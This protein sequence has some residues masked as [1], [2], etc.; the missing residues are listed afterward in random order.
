VE[1][2]R[3]VAAYAVA[4]G[5]ANVPLSGFG[6]A[7]PAAQVS[8]VSLETE[9]PVDDVR[10]EFSSGA[11]SYVQAKRTLRKGRPL[12]SAVEQWVR[13]AR[14]GLQPGRDHLVIVTGELSGP[15]KVLQGVLRRL[16]T[17]RP[18]AL[19]GKEE[20]ELQHLRTLLEPLGE[21]DQA[22]VLK[23]AS[24]H[25][26]EVEEPED[27]GA[28]EAT[29]LL[30]RFVDA[31][32]LARAWRALVRVAGV[33]ARLR[34]GFDMRGWLAQLRD[35]GLAIS[36]SGGTVAA[37]LEAERRAVERYVADAERKAA[38]I[39][40]RPL[41]A[42]VAPIPIVDIDAD[43]E[44]HEEDRRGTTSL[45]WSFL[46][47][48]RVILTGLPGAGKST[49]L[50]HFAALIP[51]IDE[52][53][54]IRA[55]LRDIDAQDH[56]RPF[57]DR[58]L[59]VALRDVPPADRPLLVAN[60]S[61]RLDGGDAVLLLDGLDETYQRRAAVVAEVEAF[62]AS[63]SEHVAVL[64]S[65]R[66]VA[67]GHAATIGWPDLRLAPPKSIDRLVSAVL[68]ACQAAAARRGEKVDG[69]DWVA[70]RETWVT[71]ALGA[72][73][74][75]RETPLVPILLALLAGERDIK[76]LPT[77]RANVMRAVVES[78]L[79]RRDSDSARLVVGDLVG[80]AAVAAAAYVFAVEARALVDSGGQQAHATLQ[81]SVAAA[82]AEHWGLAPGPARVAADAAIRFWD[83]HGI[84]VVSGAQEVVTPR[85]PLFSEIGDAMAIVGSTPTGLA[86]WV[87]ERAA[88][89]AVESL[90][91]AAGLL[92]EAAEELAAAAVRTGDKA[93]LHGAV[94]A[95]LDGAVLGPETVRR[96][97][98]AHLADIAE[99]GREGWS[100]LGMLLRLPADATTPEA[101]EAVLD[102]YPDEHQVIARASIALHFRMPDELRSDPEVL[103]EALATS[104]IKRL[105]SRF[106]DEAPGWRALAVDELY[107]R[108]IERAAELLVG[109]VEGAAELVVARLQTVSMATSRRLCEVLEA[110]GMGDRVATAASES[111]RNTARLLANL[112]Y[113]PDDYVRFLEAVASMSP[114]ANLEFPVGIKLD[115]LADFVETM[116]LN[117]AG[118]W[119]SSFRSHQA[120]VIELVATLGSFDRSVLAAEAAIVLDRIAT[121]GGHEP[122]FSLFDG[123]SSR[124]LDDWSSVSSPEDA[125]R[126]LTRM[127]TWGLGSARLAASAL[128][129]A[130]VR[131]LAVPKLRE[132][133]P[134]LVSSAEHERV[135][136]LTLCSMV[137]GPEPESWLH[138]DD[139]ILRAV[140][141][142][143]LEPVGPEGR[144]TPQL[145]ELLL[146]ADRNVRAEAVRRLA[147]AAAVDRDQLLKQVAEAAEPGW[148]CLSCRTVNLPVATSCDE[149]DC[150]RV[151]S[152]PAADARRI[153]DG[154]FTPDD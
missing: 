52:W 131:E 13:A 24:M 121:F 129:A 123:A 134:K 119:G 96:V 137:D 124:P 48:G 78:L 116:L 127:L 66:D 51:R 84:F 104:R 46:R 38:S 71:S 58:L 6:V 55:S 89:G 146:D 27:T 103:L 82:L 39:D 154:T 83:E 117:D 54:P 44:V 57:R 67:Y 76:R 21:R 147:S 142:A 98:H 68:A 17:D 33:T 135:A 81:P 31:S 138:D 91:L 97:A 144:V 73:A 64:L 92:P 143:W 62:L 150:H 56:A 18:A 11:I 3:A 90:V 145:R 59:E 63:C 45:L 128:W 70:A 112:D 12:N 148:M 20:A 85:L 122:F 43:V 8:T 87:A 36:A 69:A 125:V 132:L 53:L 80:D 9:D 106:H 86:S 60:L 141:A 88:Q 133:L 40:L 35:E 2:R 34:G 61:R 115:H 107:G 19:T 109:T 94:R 72:N 74:T 22:T 1:Y 93:L 111:L 130:P 41:G 23:C 139:P 120:E 113:D 42:R 30:T 75:L 49:A 102:S 79:V 5:L 95:Y 136:A 108:A 25:V 28:R 47:R 114:P 149:P 151:P 101:V 126:L 10:V 14:R 110:A 153:L 105:V 152:H 100:S 77:A 7:A 4:H 140:A 26:L 50:V 32:E 65:T 118:S 16:K 37:Q 29:L 15:L 99:G